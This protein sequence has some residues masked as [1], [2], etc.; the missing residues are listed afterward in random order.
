[1][2]TPREALVDA[3]LERSG[4]VFVG[5]SGAGVTEAQVTGLTLE[6]AALGFLP[7]ARLSQRLARLGQAELE[8][9]HARLL[10]AL[11]RQAGLTGSQVPLFRN[12]P[13]D[14]D[15]TDARQ[16]LW[17][18]VLVHF[19]QAEGTACLF[20]LKRGTTHVLS[21]CR[22]VVCDR[23]FD[24]A[25][26]SACPVCE[27]H[28][29]PSPFFLPSRELPV[30]KERVTF[31]VL[32]LGEDL[33]VE[34]QRLCESLCARTQ[35]LNPNDATVLVLLV[36]AFGA[37]VLQWLP[38]KL[39]LRENVARVFA[40]L[41]DSLPA[42]EVL[43]HASRY[44]TSATDVLR[45]IAAL[46]GADVSL[47]LQAYWKLRPGD[48]AARW[49]K[50]SRFKV[51]KL[52]RPVRRGL[53]ALLDAMPRE[54][55]VEDLLRHASYWV[56]VGEFLHPGEYAK[57]YPNLAFGFEV[58]RGQGPDGKSAPA[59]ETWAAKLEQRRLAEDLEGQLTLLS[60]RPG[61]LARRLDVLLRRASPQLL[62]RVQEAFFARLGSYA[63]PVLMQ[64]KA[65]LPS[66]EAK[67]AERVYFP[68]TMASH[69]VVGP[70]TRAVL[71]P[72]VT[73]PVVE[74]ISA[75]LL[76]RFAQKPRVATS[77]IDASLATIRV[78]FVERQSSPSAV[79][80]T[81]GSSLPVPDGKHVRLFLHW[82]Q[83]PHGDDTDLDLSVGFY[84]ANFAPVGVCSFY[85]LQMTSP[86]GEVVATSAGDL[87][88]A[89]YPDGAAEYVDVDLE[90]ARA[91]GA[92]YAVMTVTNY[93]G[94]AF[95]ALERAWAG[96]MF[97]DDVSG[98][99][100]DPRTVALRFG[101]AGSNGVF[102]PL[103]V[104]LAQRELHWLD[105]QAKGQLDFNTLAKANDTLRVVCPALIR[106]FASGARPSM[107]D[108]G[109]LHAAARSDVVWVRTASTSQRFTRRAGEGVEPF[110]RRLVEGQADGARAQ[111]P[112]LAG[113]TLALLTHGDLELPA[114]SDAWALF[115]EQ[116]SPRLSAAD[117][118]S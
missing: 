21:P 4:L 91:M 29:D 27:R 66:R 48:D 14:I 59:F 41:F 15:L 37:Q 1:M 76:R 38:E 79:N 94:L 54:Q 39:P 5:P 78:P 104:D 77:V 68:K 49:T 28:V 69:G 7:S 73:G 97:R 87:R 84:D 112:E 70:E 95:S 67:L 102:I 36:K 16:R 90:K 33:A 20:C 99:H 105:V 6:L 72:S 83:P 86:S 116:L 44:F 24:G 34:S 110:Y 45:L 10:P 46:S 98:Q 65:H 100:F 75:E 42:N 101:L 80:L 56:W 50:N 8:A 25:N 52:K 63:T 82:C 9:L 108:L 13:H 57:R 96:L 26:L 3:F 58:L 106:F 31:K 32:D 61:E 89:P 47:A 111:G 11:R 19:F 92:R 71:P 118:L 115:R 2:S 18:K 93:S 88:D 23:C 17:T 30:P 43:A 114:G 85:Q 113:A 53:L 60:G 40:P 62:S 22:H 64:L 107:Y 109:L 12:F 74:R 51:A 35:P 117:L 103:A 55:L 81:R